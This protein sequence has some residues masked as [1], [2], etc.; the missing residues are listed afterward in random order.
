MKVNIQLMAGLGVLA[1]IT[2]A[3]SVFAPLALAL[4]IIA[5]VWPMQAWL[6]ARI[7][8]LLALAITLLVT[9]P[10]AG[11]LPRWWSGVL[12]GFFDL[13][14]WMRRD[15]R[16]SISKWSTWLDGHGVSIA[17]FWAE[18]F[19]VR[20]MLRWA[21]QFLTGRVNTTLTFWVIAMVYL[22]LGLLE[23]DRLRRNIEI[24]R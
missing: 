5:I 23:V 13:W 22:M 12:D 18:H 16:R 6:Q 7:P 15:T 14:S 3:R 19:N 10:L 1:A 9:S 24:A 21:T 8:K 20:W 4:F 17:G 11:S 2:Y